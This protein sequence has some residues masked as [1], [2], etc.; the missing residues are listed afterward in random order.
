MKLILRFAS[1]Y[2]MGGPDA[3][4]ELDIIHQ[5]I[6]SRSGHEIIYQQLQPGWKNENN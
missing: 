2:P 3:M 5:V 6:L 4:E 1:N